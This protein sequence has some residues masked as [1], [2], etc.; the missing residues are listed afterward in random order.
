MQVRELG[1]QHGGLARLLPR[2]LAVPVQPAAGAE[3]WL[4]LP[5]VDRCVARVLR[6]QQG[7]RHR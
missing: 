6:H 7:R 1:G 2:V 5:V 4:V 3:R